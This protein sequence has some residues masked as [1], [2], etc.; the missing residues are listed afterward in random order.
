MYRQYHGRIS[1][2]RLFLLSSWEH[3]QT[4]VAVVSGQNLLQYM[5][6][7]ILNK[8]V[9]LK[10]AGGQLFDCVGCGSSSRMMYEEEI[11]LIVG[12]RRRGAIATI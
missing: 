7:Y 2:H 6:H 9:V 3:T 10:V 5:T 4:V 12:R 11:Y 8:L 1:L